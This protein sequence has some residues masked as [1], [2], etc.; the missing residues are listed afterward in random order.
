MWKCSSGRAPRRRQMLPTFPR[1]A[2]E[3]PTALM[4]FLGTVAA[5][6]SVLGLAL[7]ARGQESKPL[8][9]QRGHE[10]AQKYCTPCHLFPEPDLLTKTAWIH[11][12]QPEMAK[13]LG[14]E[15]VDFEGMPDGK[16]LAEA[17]LYPPSPIVSEEDWF[18]IWDYYRAAAPSQPKSQAAKPKPEPALK[19]FRAHKVNPH[20][21]VPM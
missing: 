6:A 16:I 3:L 19:Q 8:H 12:V 1:L 9:P 20:S 13:W 2:I 11:H 18:A 5:F 14:L 10:L 15:R 7:P 17:Q 21:G 4:N